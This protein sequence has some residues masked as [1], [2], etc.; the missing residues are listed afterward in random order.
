MS[1]STFSPVGFNAYDAYGEF[2]VARYFGLRYGGIPSSAKM[3][4]TVTPDKEAYDKVMDT[5]KM[6]DT[7][8]ELVTES[9]K[10]E[11]HLSNEA[12]K[13]FVKYAFL[14]G[15]ASEACIEIYV[16]NDV[17]ILEFFYAVDSPAAKQRAFAM[18]DKLRAEYAK[19]EKPKFTVLAM[20]RGDFTTSTVDIDPVQT[21]LA[22]NYNDD[23][24]AVDQTI[25]SAID[26]KTSGLIL[27]HGIPGTGK[28]TYIKALLTRNQEEKFIFIPNDFVDEML[29]PSFITF[30]ISQ[31][32]S[33]LVIE[34]AESVIMAREHAQN[35]SVVSTILQITDGLFSDYLNIKVICTF[36]TDVSKIDKA[37]FRKG[38]MIA[39]YEFGELS[40]DKAMG[41]LGVKSAEEL[42]EVR[43]LAE[44]YNKESTSFDVEG[45]KP[46]IG[47]G[48]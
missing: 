48:K 36:N 29:K 44:L 38:R 14:A 10:I 47:F 19:P 16:Y 42:P 15:A 39:F 20:E 30:L 40:E 23:L 12:P 43:T 22:V 34:D 37:L 46:R 41:V 3:K 45:N 1:D 17:S 35:K 24:P 6:A 28:T 2:S 33:I 26:N 8:F 21:N 25:Q 7:D 31:K 4:V 32:N 13:D 18:I 5:L 27:L 11:R 9:W